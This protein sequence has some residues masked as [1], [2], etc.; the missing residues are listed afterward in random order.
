[1]R[2]DE[3][4][5]QDHPM[6]LSVGLVTDKLRLDRIGATR[7]TLLVI[8]SRSHIDFSVFLVAVAVICDSMV[9]Q[10][11]MKATKVDTCQR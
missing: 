5:Q 7:I 2:K 3:I 6:Y 9:R 1:M 8:P 4:D 10:V 11:R